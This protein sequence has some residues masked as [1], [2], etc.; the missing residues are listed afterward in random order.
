MKYKEKI[1]AFW[2]WILK[3][4]NWLMKPIV[5]DLN[6]FLVMWFI[7]CG[8][9]FGY[10][11]GCFYL[12]GNNWDHGL[13]CL[14]LGTF[15]SY[16]LTWG[17]HLCRKRP[18]RMAYKCIIYFL[19]ILLEA[20]YIFVNL[21]F[22]MGI[23]ARLFTLLAETNESEASEFITTY[24]FATPSLITY[25]IVV[26]IIIVVALTEWLRKWFNKAAHNKVMKV[27]LTVLLL[28]F[29]LFGAYYSHNYVRMA[30]CKHSKDLS[31]W[32]ADFGTNALDNVSSVIYSFS[33][34]NT[35]HA[36]VA[37]AIDVAREVYN[38]PI[39]VTET[40]SLN[41]VM[42]FGE[43]YIKS[44]AALYGYEHNTTPYMI[45]ERDRG[46]LIVFNDMI[47]PYNATS[48]VQKN[49]FSLNDMSNNEYWYESPTFPTVFRHAGY[50]VYIWD[51]QREYQKTEL[52]TISV[53][54]FLYN[55]TIAKLSYDEMS[56]I[57]FKYDGQMIGDFKNNSKVPPGKHN[58][59]IFHL[60]GQHVNPSYRYPRGKGFGVFT[61][62][63]IHRTEEYVTKEVK[64]YIAD[65][66][67]ATVYNDAVLK[68]IFDIWRDKNTVVIYLPDHGDEAYDFRDHCGRQGGTRAEADYFHCDNDVPFV[69][70]CSDTFI[71]KHPE[72]VKQMRA[73]VDRPGI[74]LDVS[75]MLLRL[76]GIKTKY[77]D[78]SRDISSPSYKPKKRIVYDRYDYDEVINKSKEEKGKEDK[79]KNKK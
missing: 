60:K 47:S 3:A 12:D 59:Y 2:Q 16:V 53:N 52:Y 22:E 17:L 8:V 15:V 34:L 24:A 54:A 77:Y 76:G 73:A 69:V 19:V 23:G 74:S 48:T 68:A 71:K 31:N 75:I 32:V 57:P 49:F 38:T 45:K 26:G 14:A 1:K 28:P 10:L 58:L 66:D 70:W 37:Q 78:A 79:N 67:N 33:Y 56:S 44:H 42:V 43:S 39:E 40:D 72:L 55:D 50:K 61:A 36:D 27:V 20:T 30:I 63:S 11:V 29:I 46:N 35:S 5:E 64:E 6:F 18:I 9:T 4:A 7:N 21:N 65:Y 51:M 25:G 62:D 13:R 41:V